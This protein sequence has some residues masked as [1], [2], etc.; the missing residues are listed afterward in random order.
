MEAI[1]TLFVY[2]LVTVVMML[3]AHYAYE[4]NWKYIL[5]G[6]FFYSAVFGMRYG[7][8]R[9]FF[10]YYDNYE[11]YRKLHHFLRDNYEIGFQSFV[12]FCTDLNFSVTM[13]FSIVAFVQIVFVFYLLKEK[14]DIYIWLVFTFMMGCM[15][16]NNA[17]IIRQQLA[18]S[19]IIY[20]LNFLI[21]K[22]NLQ[23][24]LCIL[25]SYWF[26]RVSVVMLI[27]YPLYIL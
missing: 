13:F 24:L 5:W 25:I 8:G 23:F 9:D 21:E 26:H 10:Q 1:Q 2:I 16:L 17:N 6:L 18:F 15:W 14:K 4:K 12:R 20:S 7:V 11:T 27:I 3:S 22:K 19:F